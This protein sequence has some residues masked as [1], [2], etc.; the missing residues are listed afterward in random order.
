V[1]AV[2][3]QV[4]AAVTFEYTLGT[5]FNRFFNVNTPP[6][7]IDDAV[8][9]AQTRRRPA[10]FNCA[11]TRIKE[12]ESKYEYA[13]RNPDGTLQSSKYSNWD[14]GNVGQ[15][16]KDFIGQSARVVDPNDATKL[17]PNPPPGYNYARLEVNGVEIEYAYLSGA[18]GAKVPILVTSKNGKWNVPST[19]APEPRVAD[20][21]RY[22][23]AHDAMHSRLI[24][25]VPDQTT[26]N[27]H[28]LIADN[29]WRETG[30]LQEALERCGKDIHMDVGEMLIELAT[31]AQYRDAAVAAHPGRVSTV[32]H[33][34]SHPKYDVYVVG[35]L[36]DQAE[37][38]TGIASV[39]DRADWET[40]DCSQIKSIVIN[41]ATELRNQFLNNTSELVANNVLIGGFLR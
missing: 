31:E 34:T 14:T 5:I 13:K 4:G 25:K 28:H 1:G 32:L 8:S 6:R 22:T 37:R 9:Q 23:D 15:D 29:V 26:R 19:K 41:T 21:K 36:R 35:K 10:N 7:D 17:I 24:A 33:N 40:V 39:R 12:V 2:G 3:I 11:T 38:T 16:V 18:P 30:M 20:P 27:V